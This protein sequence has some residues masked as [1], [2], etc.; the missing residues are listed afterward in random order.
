MQDNITANHIMAI[1]RSVELLLNI[2]QLH[3]V[4]LI[5]ISYVYNMLCIICKNKILALIANTK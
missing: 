3:I 4:K 1:R 5:S 2:N